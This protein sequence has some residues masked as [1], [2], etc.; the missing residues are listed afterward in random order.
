[1]GTTAV[2]RVR[3]PALRNDLEVDTF[4]T[5]SS[6]PYEGFRV[7]HYSSAIKGIECG[8]TSHFKAFSE[9]EFNLCQHS[10]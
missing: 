6:V 2:A 8:E 10:I 9:A 4:A 7:D 3:I 1:M 5:F